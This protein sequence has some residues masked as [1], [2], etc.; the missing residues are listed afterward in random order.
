MGDT[1][2]LE[3]GSKFTFGNVKSINYHI[4]LGKILES[5]R[6][7]QNE[8]LEW[9]LK[10]PSGNNHEV[11][12]M[13]PLCYCVVDMKGAR[14]ICGMYDTGNVQRPCIS[15]YC[16]KDDLHLK[17]S[18]ICRPVIDLQMKKIISQQ[19]LTLLQKNSQHPNQYNAFFDIDTGGWK[20]G[21]WGMCPSEI[22]HQFYEGIVIYALDEFLRKCLTQTYR[23]NL[24]IGIK[25]LLSCIF[26]QSS[27]KNFPTGVFTVGVT[28]LSKMKGIE[29]FASIFYISL[30]L[31]TDISKTEYFAGEKEMKSVEK[32]HDLVLW[33]QL[34]E[35]MC[36]YH[37]WL[38]KEKFSRVS[39]KGKH[40]K[41]AY[42]YGL[43]ERLIKRSGKGIHTIPK[44][45]EL[46]H[47]I[48]NIEWHGPPTGYST[49]ITESNH[50]P[51]K[52]ASKH[53]QRQIDSFSQQTAK[54]LFERNIIESTYN[55]VNTFAKDLYTRTTIESRQHCSMNTNNIATSISNVYDNGGHLGLFYV[56]FNKKNDVVNF[57]SIPSSTESSVDVAIKNKNFQN[58]DLIAFFRNSIFNLLDQIG[59]KPDKNQINIP[60]F[61]TLFR[62]GMKFRGHSRS[63]K[64][65]YPD[66]AIFQWEYETKK[67]NSS[68]TKL[69]P[70]KIITFI[71]FSK[72]TFQQ[73]FKHLYPTEEIHVV[74][75]SFPT[76]PFESFNLNRPDSLSICAPTT[77]QHKNNKPFYYL[78]SINTIYDTALVVPNLGTKTFPEQVLYVFPRLY[79]EKSVS[80]TTPGNDEYEEDSTDDIQDLGG[81]SNKF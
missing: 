74:I 41:I 40:K 42:F 35:T 71:D 26:D 25:K 57:Q 79:N 65:N 5:L 80:N 36:F 29:K 44:F 9:N 43:F 53:T 77:L 39:L 46:F 50:R 6:L 37:D 27:K 70:G 75:E 68:I 51:V 64:S 23:D 55:F 22:L 3:S 31:N 66:W 14:Q 34:F 76:T 47:I 69:V 21:I 7:C 10:F 62:N 48:R 20:Y 30:F 15:C 60:C 28:T 67:N 24:E 81:W 33:K 18:K 45:H 52:S 17:K 4:I 59:N 13:F 12:F 11:K 16:K 8:G 54:R 73:K 58:S 56:A 32:K 1:G 78:V 2:D 61:T 63:N 72:V 19:D 49:I 38:M